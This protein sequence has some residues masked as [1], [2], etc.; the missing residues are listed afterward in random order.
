M[1]AFDGGR[2]EWPL[3]R[4]AVCHSVTAAPRPRG[5]QRRLITRIVQTAVGIGFAALIVGALVAT[6]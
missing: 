1:T 4:L 5:R 2:N 6:P 3:E